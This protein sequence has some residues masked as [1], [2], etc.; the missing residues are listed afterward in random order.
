M[1]PPWVTLKYRHRISR[2]WHVL[3]TTI[4]LRIYS[5]SLPPGASPKSKSHA[6]VTVSSRLLISG[7]FIGTFWVLWWEDSIEDGP[8]KSRIIPDTEGDSRFL[9][10]ASVSFASELEKESSSPIMYMWGAKEGR[11]SI[12]RKFELFESTN[13][14]YFPVRIA[15]KTYR[16]LEQIHATSRLQRLDW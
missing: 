4:F 7:A 15:N 9:K 6:S 12:F 2:G 5:P 14:V 3:L 11:A 1:L 16:G 13:W 8:N 10:I